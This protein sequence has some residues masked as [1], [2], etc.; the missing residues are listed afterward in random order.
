MPRKMLIVGIAFLSL[1]QPTPPLKPKKRLWSLTKLKR[2]LLNGNRDRV[3]VALPVANGNAP[4][5]HQ[6]P[7]SLLTDAK[8]LANGFVFF[9]GHGFNIAAA[10]FFS[11]FF[12]PRYKKRLQV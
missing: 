1:P 6:Y 5:A 9:S 8:R 11:T 4:D 7:P 12:A 2:P 3:F 10:C